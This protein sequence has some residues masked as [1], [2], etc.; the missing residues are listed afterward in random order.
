MTEYPG[1]EGS[2]TKCTDLG[3][4][5]LVQITKL[6]ENTKLDKLDT[7]YRTIKQATSLISS[8]ITQLEVAYIGPN[9]GDQAD[10]TLHAMGNLRRLAI[11][12]AVEGHSLVAESS[13]ELVGGFVLK[14]S[15][16]VEELCFQAASSRSHAVDIADSLD[17][18][19]KLNAKVMQY[20]L[21]HIRPMLDA[22][23]LVVRF[24][25]T[26]CQSFW[27]LSTDVHL[28]IP[29]ITSKAVGTKMATR[30]SSR[31]GSPRRKS[32][33]GTKELNLLD[34]LN[35]YEEYCAGSSTELKVTS[36]EKCIA[37]Y[38]K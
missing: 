17:S 8:S 38:L 30:R 12:A 24:A 32:G 2:V 15:A 9:H 23:D 31:N 18:V 34:C 35:S 29:Q 37:D 4:T 7:V 10:F 1:Q 6:L 33:H 13:D 26:Y 3:K 22:L 20:H 25:A 21:Q 11:V 36:Y 19:R 27:D 14:S 5:L 28:A 16:E